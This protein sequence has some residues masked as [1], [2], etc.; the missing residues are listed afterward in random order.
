M[1]GPPVETLE[2]VRLNWR[3]ERDDYVKVAITSPDSLG[4]IPCCLRIHG[5]YLPNQLGTDD[6]GS[7]L[8]SRYSFNNLSPIMDI[9]GEDYAINEVYLEFKEFDSMGQRQ[10]ASLLPIKRIVDP[11]SVE[12]QH[13]V[14][15]LSDT[16]HHCDIC[17]DIEDGGE[18][19]LFCRF[20]VKK[21]GSE[22]TACLT[23]LASH[24]LP[25]SGRWRKPTYISQFEPTVLDLSPGVLGISEGFR[26][27]GFA[28]GTGL[29]FDP[30]LNL[31][32]KVC[33]F[34]SS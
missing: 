29:C 5:I 18:E 33:P 2:S 34:F 25:H 20:A 28:I 19:P 17:S 4:K 32:W 16:R 14:C 13:R 15:D 23:P 26:Q 8:V 22:D 21:D 30:K 7:L 10:D 24:L 12:L 9:S 31:T 11:Q 1:H 3:F 27:A 6:E